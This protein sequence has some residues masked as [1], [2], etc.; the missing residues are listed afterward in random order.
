MVA[1]VIV[2]SAQLPVTR[3]A[4]IVLPDAAAVEY[5]SIVAEVTAQLDPSDGRLNRMKLR[6]LSFGAFDSTWKSLLPPRLAV[7]L[8]CST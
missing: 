2:P 3:L 5:S 4:W 1:Q 7:A 8:P 6:R